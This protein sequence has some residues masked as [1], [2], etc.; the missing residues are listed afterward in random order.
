[1][2]LQ[3]HE[4]EQVA[5][6]PLVVEAVATKVLDRWVVDVLGRDPVRVRVSSLA[7]VDASV[8]GM[9]H[10]RHGTAGGPVHVHVYWYRSAW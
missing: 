2:S 10:R 9:R 6:E 3:S 1:M 5:V 8:N 4:T 7:D